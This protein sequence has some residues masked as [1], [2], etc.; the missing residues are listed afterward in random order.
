MPPH[1]NHVSDLRPELT[2]PRIGTTVDDRYHVVS[3]LADGATGVVYLAEAL[4]LQRHVAIKFLH[5]DLSHDEHH[6]ERLR[7]EALALLGVKHPHCVSVIDFSL[8][9]VPYLVMDY[10]EG[11]TLRSFLHRPLPAARAL[12]IVRQVLTA[13]DY[14]HDLGIIHR[15]IKPD[16]IMIESEHGLRDHVRLLDFGLAKLIGTFSDLTAGMVLGTPSYMAPE[17]G[18]AGEI[19]IATDVYAT[20]AL[21]FELLTGKK[22]FEGSD[23][24]EVLFN[25]THR[26]TPFLRDV[27]PDQEFSEELEALVHRALATKPEH[28]F[29]TAEAML[30]ALEACPEARAPRFTLHLAFPV[31]VDRTEEGLPTDPTII[32]QRVPIEPHHLPCIE[33]IATQSRSRFGT[34]F[35]A[36]ALAVAAGCLFLWL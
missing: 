33:A 1:E 22:P 19:S 23:F 36:V 21:L 9:P 32:D 16:N 30:T 15:D 6:R 10:V 8:F 13:L 17:Q 35:F 24:G 31:P 25:Q 3:A 11:R 34:L 12:H 29:R 7:R 27:D 26:R 28:R 14:V 5:N 20:G 2:D 4:H 18:R